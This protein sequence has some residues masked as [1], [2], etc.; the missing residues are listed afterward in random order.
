[1]RFAGAFKFRAKLQTI[2]SSHVFAGKQRLL[3]VEVRHRAGFEPRNCCNGED[4]DCEVRKRADACFRPCGSAG[5]LR[6]KRM[7][8]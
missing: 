7:V 1:M 5:T 2:V 4:M 3:C 6:A 8:R